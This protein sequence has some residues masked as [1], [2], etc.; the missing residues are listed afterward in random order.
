[1]A[2]LDEEQLFEEQLSTQATH[3]F[4]E[5]LVKA[6]QELIAGVTYE[7]EKSASA[8]AVKEEQAGARFL[9]KFRRR[10][11]GSH[12]P[13]ADAAKSASPSAPLKSKPKFSFVTTATSGRDRVVFDDDTDELTVAPEQKRRSPTF[14]RL[15]GRVSGRVHPLS[16]SSDAAPDAHR[17][18]SPSSRR[19]SENHPSDAARPSLQGAVHL[20]RDR[21][22]RA[23]VT[24]A[25]VAGAI[26][27]A[28]TASGDGDNENTRRERM[29][30]GEFERSRGQ[31]GALGRLRGCLRAIPVVHPHSQLRTYWDYVVLLAMTYT[32]VLLPFQVAFL[33]HSHLRCSIHSHTPRPFRPAP[34][35]PPR[36][37][38]PLHT[39]RSCAG[40]ILSR[41]S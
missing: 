40:R 1:M 9:T 30:S 2:L 15:L 19:T 6:Q 33:P 26:S 34:A 25:S 31:R 36:A 20:A 35:S 29:A 7:K 13:A 32:L 17:D 38:R 18:D 5:Q 24:L 16:A 23:S 8:S 22:R 28:A 4:E 41:R 21:T 12:S 10:P 37:P 27:N 39:K 11:S 14:M 3:L